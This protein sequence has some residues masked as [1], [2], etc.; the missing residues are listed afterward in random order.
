M[1]T[2]KGIIYSQASVSEI[3]EHLGRNSLIPDNDI[4]LF[5]SKAIK[6]REAFRG[7]IILIQDNNTQ[8]WAFTLIV[9]EEEYADLNWTN[10]EI[11]AYLARYGKGVN[12]T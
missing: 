6:Y 10:E 5:I 3:Q 7:P 2:S 11:D 1:N 4:D 12:D 9:P 8:P